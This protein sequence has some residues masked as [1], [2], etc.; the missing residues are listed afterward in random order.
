MP[1][2]GTQTLKKLVGRSTGSSLAVTEA[3]NNLTECVLVSFLG[4]CSAVQLSIKPSGNTFLTG[5]NVNLRCKCYMNPS[6]TYSFTK[7][8][9]AVSTDSRVTLDRNKLF[10]NNANEGD[11]GTYSCSATAKDGN[12]KNPTYD[13]SISVVGKLSSNLMFLFN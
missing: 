12:V 11:S 10:I 9:V 13:L 5:T 7:D 1:L 6:G 3:M 8:G 2:L 4:T